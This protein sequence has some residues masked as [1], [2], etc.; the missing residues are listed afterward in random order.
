ML[1]VR[2]KL[3]YTAIIG[4]VQRRLFGAL[5]EHMGRSVYTGIYEPGHKR[6]D[7]SGFRCDVLELVAELGTTI[8]RYPGG[9]FVSSYRWEDGAGPVEGRPT[10]L[11]L[12]WH[13]IE[14]NEFG[15]DEFMRWTQRAQVEPMMVLNLG[16]RGMPEAL[17]LLEYANHPGGTT[18]S[19][20]RRGHG[21]PTPYGIRMW[22]LGNEMD[23]PWQ[24][25][26]KTAREYGRIAAETARAMRMVDPKLELVACGSS[27]PAMPTFGTWETTVLEETYDLVD[28]IS[29][30]AYYEEIGG[31]LESFLASSVDLERAIK[32]VVT[33]ADAVG[34]QRG[35]PREIA[36]AVDEWN[37]WYLSAFQSAEPRTEWSRAA[38]LCEEAYTAADAVVVG[39]LLIALLKHVDRVTSACLAQLVNVI[40]PI[41]TEPGGPAWRQTTFYPFALTASRAKGSV[42]LIACEAPEM[43]V[44]KYGAVQVVDAVATIAETGHIAVFA[45][46]RDTHE[47]VEL[48]VDLGNLSAS[49][50]EVTVLSDA[51]PHARNTRETPDRVVPGAGRGSVDG[52]QLTLTLP[53]VSWLVARLDVGSSFGTEGLLRVHSE[54]A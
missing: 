36:V 46:N 25:G 43:E 21:A 48:E 50:C 9:N 34:A 15:L 27:G 30:H 18:L 22:C 45:V 54:G 52:R 33:A 32:R 16:T 3:D 23:G 41:R 29:L 6:A 38:P 24:V 14:T 42:A 7:A 49:L 12:A 5:V 19:E 26:H 13:A 1:K 10:R 4:P 37:V 31:D 11:D 28:C 2:G 20:L 51:D 44:D 39:S 8:V 35:D 53:P 47:D 17:D 40:A